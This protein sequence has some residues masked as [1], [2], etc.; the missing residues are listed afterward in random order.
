MYTSKNV[1]FTSTV[2]YRSWYYY[3]FADMDSLKNQAVTRYIDEFDY[4]EKI[5][6]SKVGGSTDSKPAETSETSGS[7]ET[8]ESKP[9]ESSA[10]SESSAES[11][12]TSESKA[13]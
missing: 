9:A 11:S 3:G 8:S 12:E 6:Q 4:V 5:D 13:A 1:K 10:P 7:S 2:G